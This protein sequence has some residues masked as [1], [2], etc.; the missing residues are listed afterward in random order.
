MTS[1]VLGQ[2]CKAFVYR[3]WYLCSFITR[4]PSRC[5]FESASQYLQLMLNTVILFPF[6]R[7][8]SLAEFLHDPHK[9]SPE[10]LLQVNPRSG[11]NV[12]AAMDLECSQLQLK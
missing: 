2:L 10:Y 5:C 9:G 6:R 7:S 8:G 12:G 4:R 1:T 3:R 11:K